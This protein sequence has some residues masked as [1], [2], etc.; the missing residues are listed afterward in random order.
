MSLRRCR[1]AQPSASA[2]CQGSAHANHCFHSLLLPSRSPAAGL[3]CK[4]DALQQQFDK[5]NNYVIA[6]RDK[7][8]KVDLQ[9]PLE[10][11]SSGGSNCWKGVDVDAGEEDACTSG[12]H[13][14]ALLTSL[15]KL[16]EPQLR[17][18]LQP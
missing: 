3:S 16:L 4:N 14:Q 11:R 6:L 9:R 2:A 10:L 15:N 7:E 12:K 18:N 8:Q 5:H 13:T 17:L 1:Q